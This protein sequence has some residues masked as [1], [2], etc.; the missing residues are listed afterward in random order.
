[1]QCIITQLSRYVPHCNL[2][3]NKYMA[4]K[5]PHRKDDVAASEENMPEAILDSEDIGRNIKAPRASVT[6]TKVEF[7]VFL[8]FSVC[9]L[10][11]IYTIFDT[12][13]HSLINAAIRTEFDGYDTPFRSIDS[14]GKFSAWVTEL[15]TYTYQTS[16]YDGRT[17]EREHDAEIAYSNNYVSPVRI[18]QRRMRTRETQYTDFDNFRPQV[19]VGAGFDSDTGETGQEDTAA[20]G[21]NLVYRYNDNFELSGFITLINILGDDKNKSLSTLSSLTQSSWVD[22]KTRTVIVDFALYNPYEEVYTYV[23]ASLV[24]SRTGTVTP[25][26][27]LYNVNKSYYSSSGAKVFRTICELVFVLILAMY[28]IQQP[29]AI[30]ATYRQVESGIRDEATEAEEYA[31]T[32]EKVP[33]VPQRKK[34]QEGICRRVCDAVVRKLSLAFWVLYTHFTSLWNILDMLALALSLTA[35]VYWLK[36]VV[37]QSG[38]TVTTDSLQD[39]R[40]IDR[41]FHASKL[42]YTNRT[43]CAFNLIIISIRVL[44]YLGY[45]VERVSVLFGALD[46]AKSDIFHF[47]ILILTVMFSFVLFLFIYFGPTSSEFASI[48]KV[49]TR[50]FQFMNWWYGS[51]DDLLNVDMLIGT[52]LFVVFVTVVVFILLNMFVGFLLRAYRMAN[53]ELKN[54]TSGRDEAGKKVV[55]GIE[56]HWTLRILHVVYNALA[57]VNFSYREKEEAMDKEFQKYTSIVRETKDESTEFDREFNPMETFAQAKSKLLLTSYYIEEKANLERDRRCGRIF[58]ST[59]I[60]LAFTAVYIVLLA[61]QLRVPRGHSLVVSARNKVVYET[62]VP[63]TNG[64]TTYYNMEEIS[65]LEYLT[66]WIKNGLPMLAADTKSKY[67]TFDYI[68]GSEFKVTFRLGQ[69]LHAKT[70]LDAAFVRL[71]SDSILDSQSAAGERTDVIVGGSGNYTYLAEDGYLGN[72]GY[73]TYWD[74]NATLT[75][76]QCAAFVAD[77][78]VGPD[79]WLFAAEFVVYEPTD[80][81]F[82]YNAIVIKTYG[83]GLIKEQLRSNPLY[84]PPAGSADG[85]AVIALEVMFILFLGY[86][87]VN[88]VLEF[89]YKWRDYT[90]WIEAE[91]VDFTSLKLYQRKQKCPEIIRKLKY[92]FSLYRILDLLFF[93]FAIMSITYCIIYLYSSR[94]LLRTMPYTHQQFDIHTE[95]RRVADSQY[96]YINHSSIALMI[97]ALRLIE[98][99]QY[100]G[101]MRILTSLLDRALEDIVYFMVIFLSLMIGFAGMANIA[102]GEYSEPFHTLGDSWISCLVMLLG[103]FDISEVLNRDLATGTVFIFAFLILFSY[104]LLNI[105]LAILEINFVAAKQEYE[106]LDDRIRKLN[107]LLCCWLRNPAEED[108]KK[109]D[110]G[111]GD[112]AIL[113]LPECVASLDELDVQ[114]DTMPKSLLWWADGL[115]KQVQ[116]A[117]KGQQRLRDKTRERFQSVPEK[118]LR[119]END[120]NMVRATTGR[121]AY[122][123]YMRLVCQLMDYQAASVDQKIIAVNAE[124]RDKAQR[125]DTEKRELCR[126]KAVGREVCIELADRARGLKN[127]QERVRIAREAEEEGKESD[128]KIAPMIKAVEEDQAKSAPRSLSEGGNKEKSSEAA[129]PAGECKKPNE[130]DGNNSVKK[131]RISEGKTGSEKSCDSASIPPVKALGDDIDDAEVSE[132][133][134]EKEESPEVKKLDGECKKEND[135]AKSPR[136]SV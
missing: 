78:V 4:E 57:V 104:I 36:F 49:M 132:D 65:D 62:T 51:F 71:S 16:Y 85:V 105:F 86:Y 107:V 66:N 52:L 74:T 54:R 76:S 102:F 80:Q 134:D 39:P 97:L 1:M 115:A 119:N 15:I 112:D 118:D 18:V 87:M 121:K 124:A 73:V 43:I 95:A 26:L 35:I 110:G 106:K 94:G 17:R 117:I 70:Q 82:L 120:S 64:S 42:L 8:T 69:N 133:E 67:S 48:P 72:G 122:L 6:T 83:S 98:Y 32:R 135:E 128:K 63:L 59:I 53:E 41:F 101:N 45:V 100:A 7:A 111:N 9:L 22:A 19:W 81:S 77:G 103:E 129:V 14:T 96:S 127:M 84:V 27:S 58:Y 29:F 47:L 123:H 38:Y 11:I 61:V 126:A 20:Y 10:V 130:D 113:N 116:S 75:T 109:P 90:S 46:K 3:E 131:A 68:V 21:P 56:V 30:F 24:F 25:S 12:E 99:L 93:A 5:S 2:K 34:D 60:F 13:V 92:I 88:Y 108:R 44:K 89:I 91:T 37:Y 114:V 136:Q 31:K 23:Y 33:V 125:Y 40:T 55:F 50:L 79:M 28:L